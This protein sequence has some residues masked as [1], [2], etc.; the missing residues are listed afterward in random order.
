MRVVD[1][2]GGR[3]WNAWNKDICQLS[4]E[5]QRPRDLRSGFCD[6]GQQGP[7][8]SGSGVG[9]QHFTERV[10]ALSPQQEGQRL[11]RE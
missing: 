8:G 2:G 3:L 9:L 7:G 10:L 6:C 5:N 4:C 1:E 11:G